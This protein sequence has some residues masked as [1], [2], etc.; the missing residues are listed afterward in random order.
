VLIPAGNRVKSADGILI[1]QT[2]YD[3]NVPVGTNTITVAAECLTAGDAGNGRAIG[4]INIILDPVAYVSAATNTDLTAGGTKEESDD[5]L[6]ERISLA[7]ATFSVAGPRDAY[8]FFA[9]GAHPDIVDVA[10]VSLTPG[11]VSVYPLMNGGVVPTTPILNL[12]SD[13]L[14][15]TKVRPL[16]DTVVVNAPTVVNY[17][18]NVSL[19]IRKGANSAEVISEVTAALN[20]FKTERINTL[21]LDI[22]REQLIALCMLPGKVYKPT[23]SS[24]S[25]DIVATEYQYTNCTGITVTV[26]SIANE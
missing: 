17:S 14:N 3:V 11:I 8:K 22:V 6:R 2:L 7:S 1:F 10:V 4:S 5:E 24:P 15:D 13:A 18:I 9:K 26:S 23:L 19:I 12:V 25:S 16:C 20:A 21:G